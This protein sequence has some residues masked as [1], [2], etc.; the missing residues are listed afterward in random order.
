MKSVHAYAIL[1][2]GFYCCK[3][4]KYLRNYLLLFNLGFRD[5]FQKL[6]EK[7]LNPKIPT[8]SQLE[9]VNENQLTVEQTHTS[10]LVTKVFYVLKYIIF[11]FYNL[12]INF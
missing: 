2:R 5:S 9:D 6:I 11:E 1:Y 4:C 12:F 3:S 10:R 7:G 8:C